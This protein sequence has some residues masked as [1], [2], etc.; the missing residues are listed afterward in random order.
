MKKILKY[1]IEEK[2]REKKFA[3]EEQL[4][5]EEDEFKKASRE[6][7]KARE[8]LDKR[9]EQMLQTGSPLADVMLNAYN[10]ESFEEKVFSLPVMDEEKDQ[11]VVSVPYQPIDENNV[12][13]SY[14]RTSKPIYSKFNNQTKD[15]INTVYKIIGDVLPIE[16]MREALITKIEEELT[17]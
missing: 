1:Y 17:K 8:S 7:T 13:T 16:E 14:V 2:K 12:P 6:A 5:K 4:K 11:V 15:V 3:S 10:P 9:K